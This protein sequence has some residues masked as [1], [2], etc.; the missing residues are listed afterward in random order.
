MTKATEIG[1]GQQNFQPLIISGPVEW[2]G[3]QGH[4][5]VVFK[6]LGCLEALNRNKINKINPSLA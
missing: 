2:V 1:W 4:A 5:P 6:I 3:Q